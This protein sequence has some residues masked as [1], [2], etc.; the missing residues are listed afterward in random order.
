MNRLAEIGKR[1]LY[2]AWLG[3]S[4]SIVFNVSI[5]DWRLLAVLVPTCVLVSVFNTQEVDLD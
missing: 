2:G 3:G 4:L 1:S 5:F